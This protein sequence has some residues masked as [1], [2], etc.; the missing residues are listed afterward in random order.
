MRIIRRF[1]QAIVALSLCVFTCVLVTAPTL[2]KPTLATGDTPPPWL[3]L[4]LE[5]QPINTTQFAGK[6]LVITFWASWCGPCKRELPILEGLQIAGKGRIQVVAINTEERDQFR[7]VAKILSSLT[8]M[9]SHDY[10]HRAAEAYGVN[11]IP[12]MVMI[13]RDGKILSVHQGYGEGSLEG[14]VAEINAALAA[15]EAAA[16]MPAATTATAVVAA[17]RLETSAAQSLSK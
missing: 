4:N 11:G 9:M 10:S 3:G 12:H 15:P 7:K 2:A 17:P 8:L 1:I 16:V 13:G 6:V 14:I 5:G